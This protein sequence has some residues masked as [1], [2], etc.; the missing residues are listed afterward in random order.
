MGYYFD[1][2]FKD[3]QLWTWI[4][5]KVALIVGSFGLILESLSGESIF[6][7]YLYKIPFGVGAALLIIS[8]IKG[9]KEQKNEKS[10]TI[11]Q[12]LFERNKR[13]EFRKTILENPS[14]QT[15]CYQC[16]KFDQK[17]KFCMINSEIK[18]K[19]AFKTRFNE[20]EFEFCLYWKDRDT[21]EMEIENE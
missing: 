12:E 3:K 17:K 9:S 16:E 20:S 21:K 13:M 6:N 4:G 10:Q 15:L 19:K 18:N 7:G 1:A 11:S 5:F 8:A 2:I 14:F